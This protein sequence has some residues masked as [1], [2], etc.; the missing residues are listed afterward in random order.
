MR[1]NRIALPLVVSLALV[2]GSY[3]GASWHDL[4][5]KVG[6]T[7]LGRPRTLAGA[8]D[9]LRAALRDTVVEVDTG[10]PLL[11]K[12]VCPR[13]GLAIVFAAP[14]CPSSSLYLLLGACSEP[15]SVDDVPIVAVGF[16]RT[17]LATA[18]VVSASGISGVRAYWKRRAECETLIE[19]LRRCSGLIVAY[20]KNGALYRVY[21]GRVRD[22]SEA[23]DKLRLIAG[24]VRRR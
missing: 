1:T 13:P 16:S 10:Q 5:E 22:L 18:E 20:D 3:V 17:F 7:L 21:D 23:R 2:L 14:V 8:D 11:W 15:G 9:A 19:S 4:S 24:V 6:A 12:D